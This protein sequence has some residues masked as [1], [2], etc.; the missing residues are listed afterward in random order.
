MNRLL[1]YSNVSFDMIV[2]SLYR[3]IKA[4]KAFE[5]WFD[6]ADD[7]QKRSDQPYVQGMKIGVAYILSDRAVAGFAGGYENYLYNCPDKT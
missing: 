5:W 6:L 4:S 3:S 7:I 2:I 1:L